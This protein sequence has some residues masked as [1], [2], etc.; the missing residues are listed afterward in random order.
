MFGFVWQNFMDLMER[1]G[2]VMW[3]ILALSV[4]AVALSFER[5]WFYVRLNGRNRLVRVRKMSAALRRRDRAT[6]STLA[7]SDESLYG[8]VV[9]ALLEEK[10]PVTD[11]AATEA[12]ESERRH[13]DRFMP[14]LSTIITAAPMLGILGTVLGI[15]QSFEILGGN[16]TATDPSQVSLGIAEALVTTAAGLVVAL[17]ALF[18]YNA[19]RAQLDATLSR[20]ELLAAAAM[21]PAPGSAP[22]SGSAAAP[23]GEGPPS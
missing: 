19:F 1:G 20:L 10:G 2:P 9:L 13:L 3:P 21:T 22:A 17:I 14:T 6:A 5:A 4:L 15:I 18:P 8:R 16:P 23:A 11:A 12:V 7:E